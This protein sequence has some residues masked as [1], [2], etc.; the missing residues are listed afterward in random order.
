QAQL[1]DLIESL[2]EG[3]NTKVGER[4]V[5]LSG[6]QRQRIGIARAL[7]RKPDILVLDEA[8]SALDIKTEQDIMTSIDDL[9]G[10]LTIIIVTHRLITL[11][12]CDDIYSVKKGKI[13][14]EQNL[15]ISEYVKS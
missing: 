11:K 4:G 12:N 9:K 6:G 8:T 13:T 7:Y 14:K 1:T 2:P 5:Q 3:Y 10:Q 15:I